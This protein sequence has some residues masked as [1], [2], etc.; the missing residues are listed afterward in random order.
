MNQEF[1]ID[2]FVE[3]VLIWMDFEKIH[4]VMQHLDWKWAGYGNHVPTIHE[5]KEKYAKEIRRGY[6]YFIKSDAMNYTT[7]TGGFEVQFFRDS[8]EDKD[9]VCEVKFVVAGWDNYL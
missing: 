7:G 1:N 6:A 5:V 8:K 3:E 4:S 9:I 2:A